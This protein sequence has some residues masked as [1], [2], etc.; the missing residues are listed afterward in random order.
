[1]PESTQPQPPDAP[2]VAQVIYLQ[3]GGARFRAMTG[4]KNFIAYP[5]ALVFA[6]PTN[7][8]K[9]RKVRITL[10]PSDTYKMEFF[11]LMSADPIKELTSEGVY[12]DQL[13]E[14]FTHI[15]GFYTRL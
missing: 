13:Q 14:I 7:Q 11:T 8:T 12:F 15:T 2:S 10:M 1:M 9:S 4:S 5:D 6:I 3:L